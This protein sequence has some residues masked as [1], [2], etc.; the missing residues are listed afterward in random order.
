MK[1]IGHEK[2]EAFKEGCHAGKVDAQASHPFE[3][4]PNPFGFSRGGSPFD[5]DDW[6]EGYGKAFEAFGNPLTDEP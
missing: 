5:R 2:S 4:S 6:I 1:T 3:T